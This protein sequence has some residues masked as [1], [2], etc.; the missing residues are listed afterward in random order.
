MKNLLKKVAAI[1]LAVTLLG[2]GTT[3]SK[4]SSKSANT[5]TVNAATYCPA[6]NGTKFKVVFEPS[7]TA[8][9]YGRLCNRDAVYHVRTCAV[10]GRL[11]EK[12]LSYYFYTP[13][14]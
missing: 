8:M 3:I 6:H 13:I 1:A 5:I 9:C 12:K 7:G 14:D 10:C 4:Y 11:L 2:T